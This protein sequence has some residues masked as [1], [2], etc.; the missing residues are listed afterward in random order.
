M[1]LSITDYLVLRADFAVVHTESESDYLVTLTESHLAY[2]PRIMTFMQRCWC[3][4]CNA[5]TTDQSECRASRFPIV[6]PRSSNDAWP[7][8]ATK[9]PSASPPKRLTVHSD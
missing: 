1:T 2:V 6:N 8:S 7:W 9:V 4:Q 3:N 5:L